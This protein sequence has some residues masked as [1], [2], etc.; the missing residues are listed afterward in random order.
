[1]RMSRL[2]SQTLRETP[3]EAEVASHQL[4]LRAGYIRA[5]SAG[6]FSYLP[7][8][9]RSMT[10]I[11]A[12]LRQE[13]NAIGGQE[14]T[15]PVVQPAD[16]W[17]ESGRWYQIGSEMGRF[18]DKSGHDMVLAMT[19]EEVVADLVRHEI[20]S[21]R[22]LPALIY[23]IQTKWRDD[24]RPRAGLIRV[25][26]FTMLDSY[27][28]DA[29]SE[30][31]DAQY[32]AHYQAYHNI[33]QRC[34]L[35]VIAVKSDTGM[36]G[37]KL[38]HE[39]MYLS[40]VG[41]DTLL[42][43]D[44]CGYSA[45]RQIAV[46][47][48]AP[49]A[50]EAPKPLEKVSTPHC[51]TIEDLANFLSVPTLR[52]AKAVFMIATLSDG[53]DYRELFIFAVVRGDL[54]VNESKLA[55]ALA[56]AGKGAVI[57]LRPAT[58][59]E[60]RV[61]GAEPGYASPVGLPLGDKRLL[62]VADDSVASSPNLVAGA[63]EPGYHLLNTNYGRDYTAQIVTDIA[64]AGEGS[65]CPNC[66]ADMRASRG[67][68]VGNI[69]KL[70]TRYS[71]ALGCLFVDENGEKKPVIMGSYGIG[72]G[73]LLACVAEEHHD[74]RGLCWP[75]SVAPYPAHLVVLG[76]KSGQPEAQAEDVYGK[77]VAAGLEPLFDDRP[78]SPGVKFMDADLIGIP[79]RLTIGERSLKNGGVEVKPRRGGETVTLSPAEAVARVAAAAC[80]EPTLGRGPLRF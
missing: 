53:V 18:Q 5:L 78:E 22:Q 50:A 40:P 13:I 69:F 11:E 31:L 16:I 61:I 49:A 65:A 25:R 52:T 12:I 6:I 37:G 17:Q 1:M 4:L 54:E 59:A 35:P 60:I 73:R 68:E 57:G 32:D 44:A 58:E 7:L 23:H 39:F 19:H 24:P 27:T 74:E 9:R 70:G 2:F 67:V 8:A 47:R 76:G 48:K 75:A 72:V 42:L 41:E 30:G 21:Y 34:G 14:V 56:A 10:R 43:C 29:T 55:N 3:T 71:E 15:M 64:S 51:S 26:E 33:F 46:F 66:G 80:Q 20:R 38:A 63:N 79:L 77:L 45:N 62:V 28:L 36:M